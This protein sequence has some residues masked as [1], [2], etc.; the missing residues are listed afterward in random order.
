MSP[1]PS[2]PPDPPIGPPDPQRFADWGPET[3]EI[4]QEPTPFHVIIALQDRIYDATTVEAFDAVAVEIK[5]LARD[6]P[7]RAELLELLAMQRAITLPPTPDEE[8]L[9]DESAAGDTSRF[10]DWGPDTITIE[11]PPEGA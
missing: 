9:P 10:T 11:A 6:V 4:L 5:A 2:T 3:V 7:Q 8:P 1:G